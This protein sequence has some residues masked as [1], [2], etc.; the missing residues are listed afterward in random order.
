MTRW[1]KTM[2]VAL[3]AVLLLS[4]D[5]G[6]VVAGS[7]SNK[8]D[9]SRQAVTGG[10]VSKKSDGMPEI[11]KAIKEG[12]AALVKDI[13]AKGTDINTLDGWDR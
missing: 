8:D 2:I 12:K 5:V 4:P 10:G 13:L 6:V 7:S 11:H 9:V 3:M 1:Q